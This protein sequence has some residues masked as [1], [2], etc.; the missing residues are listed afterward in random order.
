[1]NIRN[2]LFVMLACWLILSGCGP[3]E[4]RNMSFRERI[5]FNQYYLHGKRL[6][7]E[8]CSNCHQY[9]GSGLARLYPPV[10]ASEEFR[11]NPS[12][13]I[14][15]IRYGYQGELVVNGISYNQSMPE[16]TDLTPLE[17]TELLTYIYSKWAETDSL[18]SVREISPVLEI[19]R[20]TEDF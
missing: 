18:F 17:I 12:R 19:C 4:G 10:L 20:E 8:N 6:Y 13:T 9:D 3:R 11:S 1:M 15:I 5:K 14:C 7:Q 16:N 2:W